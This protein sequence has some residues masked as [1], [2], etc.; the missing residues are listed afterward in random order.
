MSAV[1]ERIAAHGRQEL[2]ARLRAALLRQVGSAAEPMTLDEAQLDELVQSAAAR[3]G[4][5][6]WRR[7]LAGAGATE[8]GLHL[9][10]AVSHPDVV[11]AHELVGAP[12]YERPPE[13]A[14]PASA[15]AEP[16]AEPAPH[17][18]AAPASEALRL[19]A[20]HLSGIE[21]LR[22]GETDLEL[23]FS[24]AGLDLIKASSGAAI[25]R[26]EWSEIRSVEVSPSRR[27]LRPGRRVQ[28][29][30]VSA[31]RG[32]ASFALPG[33]S[34]QQVSEHLDPVLTRVRDAGPR[35]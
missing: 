33:L 26:L 2:H 10:D 27:A 18:P 17:P 4:S 35:E 29:L 34:A 8:L 20:V 15:R 28:E 24:E 30:R 19:A 11:R 9:G 14:L 5:V 21:S 12:P 22:N 16:A 31:Q 25:G 32:R 1:A 7:C 23:R 13:P 3:A 6:L